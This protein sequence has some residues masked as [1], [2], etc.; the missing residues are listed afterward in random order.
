MDRRK[1][2]VSTTKAMFEKRKKISFLQRQAASQEVKLQ[3]IRPQNKKYKNY[4]SS[5][6]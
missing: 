6:Y 2:V 3:G 4:N 1:Y 5:I